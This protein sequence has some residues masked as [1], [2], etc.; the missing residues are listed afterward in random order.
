MTATV[1]GA[2]LGV[3]V[4]LLFGVV[5]LMTVDD[6]PMPPSYWSGDPP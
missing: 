2:I 5:A 4:V 6:G 3:V 1:C